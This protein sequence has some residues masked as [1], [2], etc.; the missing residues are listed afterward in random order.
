MDHRVVVVR[1]LHEAVG[2]LLKETATVGAFFA[3][4]A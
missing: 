2:R 1:G 4:R 3:R